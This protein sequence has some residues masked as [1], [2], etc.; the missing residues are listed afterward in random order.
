MIRTIGTVAIAVSL[1][2]GCG[3]FNTLN[4]ARSGYQAY[5]AYNMAKGISEAAPIFQ[6]VESYTISVDLMPRDGNQTENLKT[7]F[8][9]AA[10]E[11][12]E[13]VLNDLSLTAS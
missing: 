9:D 13:T 10:A 4:N 1:V 2:T 8:R 5:T 6:G 12:T 3:A 7:A 11:K